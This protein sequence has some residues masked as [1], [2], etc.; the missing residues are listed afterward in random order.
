MCPRAALLQV[1]CSVP[2]LP[3]NCSDY[4]GMA[5]SSNASLSLAIATNMPC[6]GAVSREL[7][8]QTSKAVKTKILE[9]RVAPRAGRCNGFDIN[10]Q[11]L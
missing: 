2:G 8:P 5:I 1:S 4:D 9:K 7:S 6:T 3:A 10:F 11:F